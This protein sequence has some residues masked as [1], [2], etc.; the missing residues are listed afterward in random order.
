[1]RR[2]LKNLGMLQRLNNV[3]QTTTS[4]LPHARIALRPTPKPKLPIPLLKQTY[5]N[6][7][8][9]RFAPLSTASQC[10]IALMPPKLFH[11]RGLSSSTSP[12]RAASNIVSSNSIRDNANLDGLHNNPSDP[13]LGSVGTP[14]VRHSQAAF[15][16]GISAIP[17]GPEPRE[18]SNA[19]F[20]VSR[21]R[22]D[23]RGQSQLATA[24]WQL[25]TSHTMALSPAFERNDEDAKAS[26]FIRLHV[27]A[28]DPFFNSTE[29]G[30]SIPFARTKRLPQSE[31]QSQ[32]TSIPNRL[33][34][35]VDAISIYGNQE[36]SVA[37]RSGSNGLLKMQEGDLL[38]QNTFGIKMGN[39]KMVPESKPEDM[40]AAGD[41][42]ANEN[43]VLLALHTVFAREHNRLA[44]E[45]KKK[46][47]T[48]N[49]EELF[50]GARKYVMAA[51]QKI[52]FYEMIPAMFGKEVVQ[53]YTGYDP[54]VDPSV[55]V[56]FSTTANRLG[57]VQ[58]AETIPLLELEDGIP[59]YHNISLE[60]GTFN[61]DYLKS[62][63]AMESILL[64]SASFSQH[65]T[66]PQMVHG[67]RNVLFEVPGHKLG[68]DLA[69]TNIMRG[70][71]H[72]LPDYNT[73]REAYGL[74]RKSTFEDITENE[75][76]LK[77]LK[78]VYTSVD[79]IDPW[80]G[81]LCETH[82]P[83]SSTG[84][85]IRAVS[86]EQLNRTRSGD[87]FWF[88]NQD[89]GLSSSEIAALL[90]ESSTLGRI[91]NQNTALEL[92]G[93]PLFAT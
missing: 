1:M 60:E 87:R 64:G 11:S 52:L 6:T 90:A 18:I 66:E 38:P 80:V 20:N 33:S 10:H 23:P 53:P 19:L 68:I 14:L 9:Q 3:P 74:Q 69:A 70:R 82:E 89:S 51:Q 55:S 2:L 93:N 36:R 16:D 71:D 45:L 30:V 75:R 91:I 39:N 29:D 5:Q 37:L 83:G 57:H 50:Q 88:E 58:V 63:D 73:L 26:D 78:R 43:I 56:E 92:E 22:L 44:R 65:A 40:M 86:M 24:M 49:D 34:S 7:P 47:P 59:M 62:K 4:S 41:P 31:S 21:F 46:H 67:L 72:G 28:D 85:T 27:P 32:T 77:G 35:F 81:M 13:N 48:W 76:V 8:L 25:V 15:T 54:T 84:E 61:P 17:T 42:R 79:E 12:D